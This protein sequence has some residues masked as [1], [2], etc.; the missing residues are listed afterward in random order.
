MESPRGSGDRGVKEG[1]ITEAFDN[2]KG[3]YNLGM[4]MCYGASF[5]NKSRENVLTCLLCCG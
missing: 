1:A 2:W 5:L 3:M 4:V